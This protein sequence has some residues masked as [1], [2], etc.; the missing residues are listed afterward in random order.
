MWNCQGFLL[1]NFVTLN[2]NKTKNTIN[3][4]VDIFLKNVRFIKSKFVR[5]VFE[6][7]N[8]VF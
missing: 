2:L 1:K 7:F 4:S 6:L 3:Y 5:E 8:L